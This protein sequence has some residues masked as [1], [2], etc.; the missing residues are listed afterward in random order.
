MIEGEHYIR[1]LSDNELEKFVGLNRSM[2][3]KA[4]LKIADD[5][6]ARRK[7][8]RAAR[9]S[10]QAAAAAP[11]QGQSPAVPPAGKPDAGG[12]GETEPP[13]VNRALPATRQEINGAFMYCTNCGHT[14]G[15]DAEYCDNCG[16]RVSLKDEPEPY[17]AFVLGAGHRGGMRRSG[18]SDGCA[19]TD[20]CRGGGYGSCFDCG[21]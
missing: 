5:E 6:M 4:E 14:C 9:A 16:H 2:Y 12:A 8:A 7:R 13:V 20:G 3:T 11:R 15:L 10:E 17:P 21:I 19:D 1:G 18:S